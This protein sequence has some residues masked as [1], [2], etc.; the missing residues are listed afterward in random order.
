MIVIGTA[1]Q[2]VHRSRIES[3][4]RPLL[5]G[6]AVLLAVV[7]GADLAAPQVSPN[8]QVERPDLGTAMSISVSPSFQV[9]ACINAGPGGAAESVSYKSKVGCAGI[10]EGPTS[11]LFVDGFETGDTGAWGAATP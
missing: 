11:M 2:P 7:W 3:W 5:I 1:H 8:F 4:R 10:V 9:R 6:A